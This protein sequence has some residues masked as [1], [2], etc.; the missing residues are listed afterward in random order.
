MKPGHELEKLFLLWYLYLTE[1]T[2]FYDF[3]WVP[4][5]PVVGPFV[6]W[7]GQ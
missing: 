6:T 3:K 2:I 7:G 4:E 5:M 1:L